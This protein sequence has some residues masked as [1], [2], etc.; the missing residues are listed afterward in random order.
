[1]GERWIFDG[2]IAGIGTASGL[3]AVVG[4]WQLS[5]FGSF[6]DVMV[7][8]ASGHRLLLAPTQE[9][10]AFI[11]ATYSFDSVKVVEVNARFEDRLLTVDAGPL[12]LRAS[13]GSRPLLGKALRIVPRALAVHTAW[14]QAISPLAG[15]LSPGSRTSGTAGSGR[16]EY[17]GVSDLHRISSA[18]VSW[19]GAHAGDLAP[20][21]PGVT[22]GFSSVPARPSMARVRTT[23]VEA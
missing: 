19:N 17:Y 14:L 13:V 20:I 15:L 7:Q 10:A 9:V 16:L 2:H 11:S 1:M 3:R 6:A 23:V 18:V 21:R 22:F 4:V 5:P 8:Q 12:Q